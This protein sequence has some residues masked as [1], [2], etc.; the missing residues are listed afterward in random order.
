ML[1]NR[2]KALTLGVVLLLTFTA[3][4]A[5]A[6]LRASTIIV[7]LST[8]LNSN[9]SAAFTIITKVSCKELG[10]VSYSLYKSNGSLVKSEIIN[11]FG[12]GVRHKTSINLS[13][14]IQDG[15]SYYI[16]ANFFADGEM[17]SLT[18]GTRTY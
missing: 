4:I 1:N 14:Y 3:S 2:R 18:S 16:T 15:N 10:T 5:S 11:N 6:A 13:N 12:S 7:Q 9:K 8:A 17:R